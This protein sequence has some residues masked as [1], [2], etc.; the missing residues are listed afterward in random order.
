MQDKTLGP[1]S[2]PQYY[3]IVNVINMM[4]QYLKIPYSVNKIQASRQNKI[5]FFI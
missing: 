4:K 1:I 3:Y 5:C 2:I